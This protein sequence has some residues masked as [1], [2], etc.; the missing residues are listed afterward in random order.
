[1]VFLNLRYRRKGADLL[2]YMFTNGA[3]ASS[4]LQLFNH[5]QLQ[6]ISPL[7]SITPKHAQN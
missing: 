7:Q 1:M 4:L 5:I 6:Q 2:G 3:E